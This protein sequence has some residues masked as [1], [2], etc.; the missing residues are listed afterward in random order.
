MQFASERAGGVPAPFAWERP[1]VPV[2]WDM[3]VPAS[4]SSFLWTDWC[5]HLRPHDPN[6]GHSP[7][8]VPSVSITRCPSVSLG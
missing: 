2:P 6:A 3:P 4:T 7:A 1:R 8:R 5:L